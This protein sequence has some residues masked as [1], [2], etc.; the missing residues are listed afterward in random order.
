MEENLPTISVLMPT[1]NVAEYVEEAIKSILN[2]TYQNIE[3]IVVDDCSTDITYDIISNLAKQDSRIVAVRNT[4]NLRISQSLNKALGLAHGK[5]IARMDGDD[6]SRPDRLEKLEEH[7]R[8]HPDISL[9]GSFSE[10]ISENGNHLSYHKLPISSKWIHRT[11]PLCSTVQHIWLAYRELYDTLGGYRECPGAEDYDFLLR[12][13]SLGY[14]F[15][16]LPEY[17]YKVRLRQGNT[18]STDGLKRVLTKQYVYEANKSK[19]PII[20]SEFEERLNVSEMRMNKYRLASEKLD[21]AKH[22][23]DRPFHLISDSIVAA[24]TSKD[25]FR[26]LVEVSLVRLACMLERKS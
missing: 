3:L 4:N 20:L 18:E 14:Q 9:V 13:D 15:A 7:L 8:N 22:E 17:L 26:Y 23:R 1:Y 2:Q 21:K 16:N 25:M 12:A 6:I 24:F 10:A 11:L 19:S 5:L